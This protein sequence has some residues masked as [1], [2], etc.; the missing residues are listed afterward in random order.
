MFV[1]ILLLLL[2]LL[3]ILIVAYHYYV[4]YRRL[5]NKIPGHIGISPIILLNLISQ[6]EIFKLLNNYTNVYY[7]V[8]K[9]VDFFFML[10]VSIRHPDDL[11]V[12]L[13]GTK[14]LEKSVQYNILHPW[15]GM[16]VLTKI[17]SAW[18]SRRKVLTPVF[19]FNILQQFTEILIKEG[20]SMTKSLKNTEGIITK[21]LIP[22][23][24][25]HT[26]NAI[27]ETAMGISLQEMGLFQQQYLKAIHQIIEL[28]NYR[29]LRLWL[30]SNWIFSLT[31]KGREQ[32]KIL[33]IFHGFIEKII[34]ERKV[35]HK[36]HKQYFRNFSKVA[37][38]AET[39]EMDKKPL[40]ML[41]LL[42]LASQE[43]LLTDSDIKEE[44]SY[45]IIKGTFTAVAISYTLA[46]LAEHKN[47][48]D[49]VR[50]EIDDTM[51]ENQGKLTKSLQDLHYLERCIKEAL[52]LYPINSWLARVTSTEAQLKSCLLPTGTIVLL[53]ICGVHRDSNFWPNPEIF[54]PDRFL[55]ENIRNRHPYSYIPF[56]AGPR[57]CIGLQ[58]AMLEMKAI[59]ASLIHNFYL[60]PVDYLKN[61]RVEF[62]FFHRPLD[63][64]RINF[65]PR[66]I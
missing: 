9:L 19:H 65:I 46:L 39:I 23:I 54:D 10:M 21:D 2:L 56:S 16:N 47:I 35:Y 40:A 53:N 6:A 52:R 30:F 25:E 50:K 15:F 31:S 12:I 26:L 20:K 32:T 45:F 49:C 8:S 59:I 41:D 64:H 51:K 48:Q 22:F 60:E 43:G 55:P 4:Q 61:L 1:T 36:H 17:G 42:I 24:S 5:I 38:D 11:Q 58:F 28:L 63:P 34:A 44:I 29:L 66:R 27:C 37:I 18:Q 62:D 33:K 14:H 57:N 7:P 3:L 13:S